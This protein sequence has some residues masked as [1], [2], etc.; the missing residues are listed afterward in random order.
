MNSI[1]FATNNQHKL[2]EVRH[3]LVPDFLVLSLQEINC[4]EE[5][6]ETGN[7]LQANALQK[8]DHVFK[9]YGITCF[10][11]D[12][13][14]EVEALNNEPGVYS[15]RYAGPQRNNEQNIDLL[16]ENLKS[17]NN[18]KAQFRTV[19]CWRTAAGAQYFEGI[20][21]GEI[22]DTRRG[23]G[24][25]GYDAVF[26]PDGFTKTFAE[27]SMEEKNQLSHRGQA[28]KKLTAFLKESLS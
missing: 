12:T 3:A 5:L 22:I 16:L 6:P 7:T 2:E 27:M 18:R 1:C 15:A 13:G 24:G 11:D 8:A 9:N 26:V 28:V 19:I 20:V 21:K 25:F 4:N 14:L 10:A 23:K 17:K